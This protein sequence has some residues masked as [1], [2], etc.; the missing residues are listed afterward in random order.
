MHLAYLAGGRVAVHFFN[1][2]GPADG[3]AAAKAHFLE[4]LYWAFAAA[5]AL[6]PVPVVILGDQPESGP[7]AG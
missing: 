3:T 7:G 6:G 2:Y 5:E 4:L 1:L